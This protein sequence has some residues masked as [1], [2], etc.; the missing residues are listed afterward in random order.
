MSIKAS[1]S[2]PENLPLYKWLK[3]YEVKKTE[4][5]EKNKKEN[6]LCY[7]THI[8]MG[9]REAPDK[10]ATYN[11]PSDIMEEFYKR[12]TEAMKAGE[13]LYINEKPK[14]VSKLVIDFDLKFEINMS[15]AVEGVDYIRC[16][17]GTIKP[18]RRHKKEK[19]REIV[20]LINNAIIKYLD[21]GNKRTLTCYVMQKKAPVI[22]KYPDSHPNSKVKEPEPEPIEEKPKIKNIYDSDSES[23]EEEDAEIENETIKED[24]DEIYYCKDGIHIV[25]PKVITNAIVKHLIRKTCVEDKKRKMATMFEELGY[26][27]DI[28]D[29]FDDSVIERNNWMMY[30]SSKPNPTNDFYKITDVVNHTFSTGETKSLYKKKKDVIEN[31]E[32]MIDYV[33]LLS[34]RDIGSPEIPT[35]RDAIVMS[36]IINFR[37]K[38]LEAER[39]A[40]LKKEILYDSKFANHKTYSYEGNIEIVK[41]MVNILN[42]KRA[43]K[44]DE[45]IR[46]G[47]CLYNIDYNLLDTWIEFSKKSTNEAHVANCHEVCEDYWDRMKNEGLGIGSLFMWAKQDNPLMYNK[48]INEDLTKLLYVAAN[49]MTQFDIAKIVHKIFANQ[50]VCANISKKKWYIYKDHKWT[51]NENAKDLFIALSTRV[52]GIANKESFKY[53]KRLNELNTVNVTYD[54]NGNPI[55]DENGEEIINKPIEGLSDVSD[56]DIHMLGMPEDAYE[57]LDSDE[58]ECY[59]NLLKKNKKGNKGKRKTDDTDGKKTEHQIE[60]ERL[61]KCEKEIELEKEKEKCKELV[62]KFNDLSNRLKTTAFKNNIIDEC[63]RL[64]H[65]EGFEDKLDTNPNLMVFNNGV[66]DFVLQEFR[67]GMP[68]DMVSYSTNIDYMDYDKIKYN[69]EDAEIIE[70]INEFMAKIIRDPD[71]RHY[72]WKCLGSFTCGIIK[73][74][75]FYIYTGSGGNGKSILMNLCKKA[76]G[77]YYHTMNISLLANKRGKSNETNSEMYNAKGKRMC[78]MQ[79]PDMNENIQVGYMKEITG[80]DEVSARGLYKDKNTIY[81]PQFNVILTCNALP[82]IG[83]DDEGTWRRIR[84][85]DYNSKFTDNPDPTQPHEFK[86]DPELLDKLRLWREHF[87]SMLIHYYGVYK[88]EGLNEPEPVMECTNQYQKEND[89]MKDFITTI[90]A[91]DVANVDGG[92]TDTDTHTTHCESFISETETYQKYMKWYRDLDYE[93]GKRYKKP[94]FVKTLSRHIKQKSTQ[95]DGEQTRCLGWYGWQFADQVILANAKSKKNSMM[96]EPEEEGEDV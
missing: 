91:E 11:I 9:C 4:I 94:E 51:D 10:N 95:K 47:W 45:W 24:K 26:T 68:E 56:I 79:E 2:T 33:K 57:E 88:N 32:N 66:Y 39:N 41:K 3:R 92:E 74:H 35:K 14:D 42:P 78:V 21:F 25:Y 82:N 36:K 63:A 7:Y 18:R 52:A 12:Y 81:L 71:V 65:K 96:I 15:N 86:A 54:E 5:N 6:G 76:F 61:D 49:S 80:G 46:V 55:Y 30:G 53:S 59:K 73:E 89:I 85:V 43:V 50:F 8:S 29:I 28:T 37:N 38:R 19:I 48:I 64:F 22:E 40:K 31:P 67:D 23:D 17:D 34:V 16:E 60:E 70:N 72:M 20:K 90:L 77:D 93:K 62:A 1:Q 27:N 83:V 87:M 69:P 58:L 84:V 13:R 75:R 44:F